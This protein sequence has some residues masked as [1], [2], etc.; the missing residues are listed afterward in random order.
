[1]PAQLPPLVLSPEFSAYSRYQIGQ[2]AWEIGQWLKL[3]IPLPESILLTQTALS[4][5]E[6]TN[7]HHQFLMPHQLKIKLIKHYHH[8]IDQ[9]FVKVYVPALP[10]LSVSNVKGDANL[11]AS[12]LE[13]YHEA[14]K[15]KQKDFNILITR[16][17]QADL[18]GVVYTQHPLAH[19]KSHYLIKVAP[20]IYLDST[21][22]S[23]VDFYQVDTRTQAVIKQKK[24]LKNL[25]YK[26]VLD[27][28][29]PTKSAF[30]ANKFILSDV[31]A[32][33]IASLAHTIALH[34][35]KPLKIRFSIKNLR[36]F[37]EDITPLETKFT[38]KQSPLARKAKNQKLP[39]KIY[40]KTNVPQELSKLEHY[41]D[42]VSF[43][44]QAAILQFNTYPPVIINQKEGRLLKLL[45]HRQWQRLT[46]WLKINPQGKLFFKPTDLTSRQTSQL[47]QAPK[48]VEVNADLG[49]RGAAKYLL[50]H[51]LL[52][53]E[54]AVVQD[55]WPQE[56]KLDFILPFA[57]TEAEAHQIIKLV[58]SLAPKLKF[59]FWLEV[60]SPY[61]LINLNQF[62]LRKLKGVWL[63]TQMLQA[64]TVAFDLNNHYLN[65]LYGTHTLALNYLLKVFA[66]N[67]SQSA[68]E[69][70]VV[71]D[72]HKYQY[73]LAET[74][75]KHH[76]Q[77][78]ISQFMLDRTKLAVVDALEREII[79]LKVKRT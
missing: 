25:S 49:L 36:V 21:E 27:A 28:V 75:V 17:P 66:N 43:S 30:K 4:R 79:N 24:R 65:Q 34:E 8:F 62:P 38:P 48:E 33:T 55:N 71:L 63:N 9:D 40:L 5:I 73:Y 10:Q 77:I 59:N 13:L 20:G 67:L 29:V 58:Q 3:N 51:R 50:D 53:F 6:K 15:Q 47:N 39:I 46:Q 22:D 11:V 60:V 16:Q 57:R 54:L 74:A 2:T 64:T 18:S 61:Q 70:E 56:K 35:F 26:R 45:L 31:A 76:W 41:V 69:I 32:K 52:A 23:Q 14:K 68:K 37:I 72:M 42:G 12:V 1:M 44:H 7:T 78:S 19:S